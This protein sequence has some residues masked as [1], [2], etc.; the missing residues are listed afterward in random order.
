MIQPIDPGTGGFSTNQKANLEQEIIDVLQLNFSEPESKPPDKSSL[1]RPQQP[2]EQ[3][4]TQQT[5]ETNQVS[6]IT[7]NWLETQLIAGVNT[8]MNSNTPVMISIDKN[9]L[10][11][12]YKILEPFRRDGLVISVKS[13]SDTHDSVIIT[14][15]PQPVAQQKSSSTNTQKPEE[16]KKQV[17]ENNPI[18]EMHRDV[19]YQYLGKTISPNQGTVATYDFLRKYHSNNQR[20]VEF[21]NSLDHEEQLLFVSYLFGKFM[22]SR[23]NKSNSRSTLPRVGSYDDFLALS[24][25]IKT[26]NID[27]EMEGFKK[28][29]TRAR[30]DADIVLEELSRVSQS[31]NQNVT[32]Y[33]NENSIKHIRTGLTII[34]M[35]FQIDRDDLKKSI[36]KI[37][38]NEIQRTLDLMKDLREKGHRHAPA[39]SLSDQELRI[40]ALSS[41]LISSIFKVNPGLVLATIAQESNF[42]TNV[43]SINGRGASQQTDLGVIQQHLQNPHI[44]AKHLSKY[45]VNATFLSTIINNSLFAK[46]TSIPNNVEGNIIVQ[47]YL[48]SLTYVSKAQ[49]LRNLNIDL[50]NP[51]TTY[52]IQKLAE[53]YNG[54]S[55]AKM[56]G[57]DVAN[58]PFIGLG[59]R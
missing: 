25:F 16:R 26:L 10:Q 21:F 50:L 4:S 33:L 18:L 35:E 9:N 5:P 56:Y 46:Y 44:Y 41:Q 38:M 43:H 14:I 3:S 59:I 23:Y 39:R 1:S 45:G 57:N 34:F 27:S 11:Q 24:E 32:K 49:M 54:S 15:S 55:I 30:E 48:A 53:A 7:P 8:A 2:T 47:L 31:Q 28:R 29:L 22:G 58:S 51:K 13:D 40:Y 42:R 19:K 6:E 17:M 37:S 36:S 12:A 20:F 52:E